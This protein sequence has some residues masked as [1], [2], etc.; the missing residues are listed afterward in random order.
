MLPRSIFV[1]KISSASG[2]YW[3]VTVVAYRYWRPHACAFIF[4]IDC[5]P[6]RLAGRIECEVEYR[7]AAFFFEAFMQD[8][9]AEQPALNAVRV[10]VAIGQRGACLPALVGRQAYQEPQVCFGRADVE[11]IGVRK[12]A[13]VTGLGGAGI[14]VDQ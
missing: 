14:A 3:Q 13:H 10:V 4:D 9:I 6:G 11:R 8:V 1:E 7:E 5:Y 12:V 2:P